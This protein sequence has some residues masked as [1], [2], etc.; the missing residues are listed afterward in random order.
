MNV[1]EI[2]GRAVSALRDGEQ[3]LRRALEAAPA[4][5]SGR[6]HETLAKAVG[7]ELGRPL[8]AC[9]IE[10]FPDG[11][12]TVR[13]DEHMRGRDVFVV[14]PTAAPVGEN[15]LELALVADALHRVGAA[16]VT[17][18]VPYFGFARQERRVHPGEP[19]G[20]RVAADLVSCGRF[21]RIVV[22]DLHAPSVEGF[23]GVPVEHLSAVPLLAEAVRKHLRRDTV[24]VS[25]DLGGAKLARSYAHELGRPVAIVH[26]TRL[27]GRHVEALDVTGEVKGRSCVIVDDM[28]A[29][30]GTIEAAVNALRERGAGDDV[31]VVATHAVL[32]GNALEVLSRARI[33]RLVTTDTLPARDGGAFERVHVSI[34]PLLADAVRRLAADRPAAELAA[35]AR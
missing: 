21:A 15:I 27:S 25:P 5:V 6:A 33:T 4:L 20:A 11:E 34:A 14:Q 18:L 26:K 24:V 23:F 30:G 19:L 13:V 10:R 1:E 31:T 7:L 28:I 3:R 8:E 16:R 2:V 22:V 32:A 9:A 17:A 35:A 29:T 12:T